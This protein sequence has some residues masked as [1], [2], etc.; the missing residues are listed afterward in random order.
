MA[1]SSWATR[2]LA[3]RASH[4]FSGLEDHDSSIVI[5]WDED[6]YTGIAGCCH[7]PRGGHGIVLGGSQ[8]P[9]I[10]INSQGG[11]AHR[12]HVGRTIT[13]CW[14]RSSTCGTSGCLANS[15]KIGNN[16][17]LTSLFH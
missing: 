16:G 17:L 4:E 10:V 15:C 13:R 7:S 9:T 12:S 1:R 6:D 8:V 3:P 5:T 11:G 14:R 2:S